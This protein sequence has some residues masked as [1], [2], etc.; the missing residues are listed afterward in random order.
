MKTDEGETDGA[1]E[2]ESEGRR[3]DGRDFLFD[4]WRQLRLTAQAKA[5]RDK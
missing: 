4:S 2:E 1:D 5:R 3:D